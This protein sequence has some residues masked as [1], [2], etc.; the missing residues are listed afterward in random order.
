MRVLRCFEVISD[1]KINLNKSS[2]VGLNVD[3]FTLNNAAMLQGCKIEHLP[4]KY[5][6]LPLSHR[7]LYTRD[8]QPVMDKFKKKLA[9]W[10]GPLLSLVGRLTLIKSALSSFPIY[11]MSLYLMLVKMLSKLK[12]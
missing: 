7:C 11:F 9:H 3:D 8:W 5:L 2:L 10:K 4:I 12:G 1:L 6:G